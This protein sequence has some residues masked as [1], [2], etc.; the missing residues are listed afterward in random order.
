MENI[1]NLLYRLQSHKT[2]IAIVVLLAFIIYLLIDRNKHIR[3]E[4][5]LRDEMEFLRTVIN[6]LPDI[7]CFKNAEG[8]WVEANE[9]I[10]EL[11]STDDRII[12][13]NH[14]ELSKLLPDFKE[15]LKNC[16]KTDLDI[17][18]NGKT[19][20][21]EEV[22]YINSENKRIFEVIKVPLYYEDGS[23]KGLV[24]VGREITERK[25]AE[26]IKRQAEE[27][28]KR[29]NDLKQYDA[30]RTEFF[31]NLSH[32][33]RTPLNM[34]MAPVQLIELM[35]ENKEKVMKCVGIIKQNCFRLIRLINNIIDITKIESGYITM[36]IKKQNIVSVVEDTV[37]SASNY[38][39]NMGLELIFDTDIEEKYIYMDADKFE[40]IILNL[41][42]NAIK[43]TNP[44]GSIFVNMYDLE[45]KIRISVKDTGIG[46][47]ENKRT[48]IFERFVQVD[49]S[50]S[51]N[52]EGSG[53]G[54]SLVKAFVEKHG[55]SISINNEY[56]DGTEFIMD[57]PTHYF[58]EKD[59]SIENT[60][61]EGET[62]KNKVQITNIEFSDIY[63]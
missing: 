7:I 36:N 33:L 32:E 50:L 13:K 3:K 17:W 2:G 12:G 8:R 59:C 24:V 39:E 22:F 18:H 25:K 46:I 40:R 10:M 56:E 47:P 6:S 11:Y 23:K 41:L 44:G 30:V 53:I 58:S 62:L 45:G 28:N 63:S 42:S 34:I 60:E 21:V 19:A 57:I 1:S 29:L 54:L 38:I 20:M 14:E 52:T 48:S 61:I 37:I 15:E 5:K 43:F 16:E 26:E 55:G 4:K 27:S 51:R 9:A 31:A 49:K 35:P